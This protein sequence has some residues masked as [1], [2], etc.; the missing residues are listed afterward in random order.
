[1]NETSRN[2]R[3]PSRETAG[4]SLMG[5][6]QWPKGTTLDLPPEFVNM[7]PVEPAYERIIES[8]TRGKQTRAVE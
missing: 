8:Y 5:N 3:A 2:Q 6:W 1:M 7:S 4:Q